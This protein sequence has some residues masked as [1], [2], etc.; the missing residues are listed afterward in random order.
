MDRATSPSA[1]SRKVEPQK[2]VVTFIVDVE[3]Q[4]ADP[5]VIER[6]TGP[7]GDEWREQLYDLHTEQ[8]VLKH[9]AYNCVANGCENATMLDGWADLPREAVRM[10]VAE[11]DDL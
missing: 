9:L 1:G 2:K 10:R 5:D 6:V 8:D 11:V 7:G 4:I 3:L